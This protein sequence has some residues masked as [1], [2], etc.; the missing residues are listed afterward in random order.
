MSFLGKLA[1]VKNPSSL[2]N[3]LRTRRFSLFER[4]VDKL[5]KPVRII[6]IGG[7]A[8]F[9]KLRGW[10][11]NSD[12]QITTVNINPSPSDYS[13]ISSTYGDARDLSQ[14]ADYSFDVSFSNSV[15]EHLFELQHQKAMAHEHLRLARA[16]WVQTPNYWFPIEPHFH[17]PGWQWLP[18]STRIAIIRKVGV[19]HRGRCPD[20]LI[21][22]RIVQ[23]IRLLT[24][25]DLSKMF[26]NGIIWPE[27]FAGFVKSWVCYG[28]FASTKDTN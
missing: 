19:G 9:W 25:R 5:Q 22:T 26:P 6:D 14:F 8:E 2:S 20:R 23:E 15:I 17:F 18:M 13:N 4:L 16:W 28:G 11:E 12:Y 27:R 3:R 1:D 21:A 24:R 7:T 10:A